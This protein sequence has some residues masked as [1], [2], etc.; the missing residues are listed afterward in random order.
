MSHRT[1]WITTC[2]GLLLAA[3][4]PAALAHQASDAYLRAGADAEGRLTLQ[5]EV[6]LRDLDTVLDLDADAD[7]RLS[8]GEVRARAGEIAE[9][10]VAHMTLDD[11]RCT[12]RSAAPLTLDR[13][14]DGTYAVLRYASDCAAAAGPRLAYGL[15][16]DTDPTHRGLL[17]IADA[18][19]RAG[20]PLRSL[21][22]G[23]AAV[24]LQV[25]AAAGHGHAHDAA[26]GHGHEHG[27]AAPP[28]GIG[29]FEGFFGHGL[30][31]ILIGADH[32][33]FI[34]CLLLPLVLGGRDQPGGWRSRAWPL[35]ALV[36]A[37]TVGHS[38]TLA[39][40][41]WRVLAVPPSVIEPLIALTIAL[42]AL[43]NLRP[44]LGR[45]RAL[46]AFGFG[47]IHGFGFAGPLLELDLAP[48]AMAWALLQFNL[49]VEAGQLLVVLL[50]MLLLWPLRERRGAPL[51]ERG[52]S[53]ALGLLALLWFGERVLDF[54]VLP[55]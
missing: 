14:A 28:A 19:G 21:A 53:V 8:W 3:L 45:R 34:V 51:F 25:A 6:A 30:H 4:A 33:L 24:A 54:K 1:R 39:L 10:V 44:F 18:E 11:G 5:A 7:G 15:F 37:F 31:H 2:A 49:G 40:A 9:H 35:F 27:H 29:L 43:D 47:L 23:G 13:K 16:R 26:G 17:Q 32:V 20:A 46:A 50:A 42:T 41:S 38:I 52:A 55:V 36:T 48:L 22:P 12:L